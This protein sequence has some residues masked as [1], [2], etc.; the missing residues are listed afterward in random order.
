M[1]SFDHYFG[2]VRSM[3]VDVG[4]EAWE[5]VDFSKPS[6]HWVTGFEAF[7]IRCPSHAEPYQVCLDYLELASLGPG[8]VVLDLG[9]YAGLTAIAFSKAVGPN[10][11]VLV[12]EPD[13]C[14]CTCCEVNLKRYYDSGG[15]SNITL[16]PMAVS[17]K[18]GTLRFSSEGSM[19]SSAIGIVGSG[20]GAVLE[21]EATT[22]QALAEAQGLE[23]VDFVKMDIEGSEVNV[24]RAAGAFLR[25]FHPRL[26]V[27]PHFFNGGRSDEFFL[28]WL[29]QAGYTCRVL[30]QTG[31][32]L[33]LVVAEMTR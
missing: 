31:Y 30:E 16:L 15:W 7:Q 17:D 26:I 27:E 28:P 24:L 13:P 8:D 25:R 6:D 14:N 32:T 10:G 12:L 22:L 23:K 9:G 33:P 4:G 5:E 1:E 18:P 11:R 19:G 20:R 29:Q 3:T 2:S 21:V